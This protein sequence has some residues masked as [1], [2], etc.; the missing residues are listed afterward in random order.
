MLKQDIPRQKIFVVIW[1][2]G[3]EY[4]HRI[5][6]LKSRIVYS[7]DEGAEG[8]IIVQSTKL[9]SNVDE[10]FDLSRSIFGFVVTQ[11]QRDDPTQMLHV[12]K[13]YM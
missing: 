8:R 2:F 1:R 5:V 11:N 4:F 6:A 3:F 9:V 12:D 7:S 13:T 10:F